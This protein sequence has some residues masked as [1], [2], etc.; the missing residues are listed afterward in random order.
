MTHRTIDSTSILSEMSLKKFD[1]SNFS[2]KKEHMQDYLIVKVLIE[3]IENV[4]TLNQ[5]NGTS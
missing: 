3:L 2:Y 1:G 5:R 4:T